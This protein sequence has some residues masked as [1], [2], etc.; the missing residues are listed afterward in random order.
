[1]ENVIDWVGSMEEGLNEPHN[2]KQKSA[3]PQMDYDKASD[4]N[5]SFAEAM[6][7]KQTP[8]TYVRSD[9]KVRPNDPCP[10]GSGL[11]FKKCCMGKGIYDKKY[12]QV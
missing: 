7:M 10:C 5:D 1:M 12:I 3:Q 4:I 11:K 2:D 9:V 6:L 8:R